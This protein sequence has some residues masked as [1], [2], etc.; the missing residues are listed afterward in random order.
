[1]SGGISQ[2]SI[3]T[4]RAGQPDRAWLSVGRL[5]VS[6]IVERRR[7]VAVTPH[8]R[9]TPHS[10]GRGVRFGGLRGLGPVPHR[11]CSS[12]THDWSYRLRLFARTLRRYA[13]PSGTGPRSESS[14]N[15][16]L[17]RGA[18]GLAVCFSRRRLPGLCLYVRF[19]LRPCFRRSGRVHPGVSLRLRVHLRVGWFRSLGRRGHVDARHRLGRFT[20]VCIDHAIDVFR[21]IENIRITDHAVVDSSI[22]CSGICIQLH[23]EIICYFSVCGAYNLVHEFT[24]FKKIISFLF[25]L[26][27]LRIEII[28]DNTIIWKW[29]KS[30]FLNI[31]GNILCPAYAEIKICR[32]TM[33]RCKANFSVP[34]SSGN[35]AVKSDAN[36]YPRT[37]IRETMIRVSKIAPDR[38]APLDRAGEPRD[39]GGRVLGQGHGLWRDR[40]G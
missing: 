6:G 36:R 4:C 11:T 5:R 12:A 37:A 25:D 21:V 13:G 39:H 14:C 33:V 7:R 22:E 1:M 34:E 29:I 27:D 26:E 2:S 19:W 18:G 10:A 16:I 30:S 8:L 23:D 40:D 3:N 9:S 15:G 20:P 38:S 28:L 24:Q 17:R 31:L 35:K 32:H